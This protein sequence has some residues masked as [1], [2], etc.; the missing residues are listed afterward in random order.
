[1][2]QLTLTP[3]TFSQWTNQS[4]TIFFVL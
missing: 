4:S 3:T 1:M 2:T